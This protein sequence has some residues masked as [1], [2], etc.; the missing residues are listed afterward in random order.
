[1]PKFIFPFVLLLLQTIAFAEDFSYE[2]NYV[3]EEHSYFTNL[4]FYEEYERDDFIQNCYF[5][6]RGLPL[7]QRDTLGAFAP[8][9]NMEGI[10]YIYERINTFR[11]KF[12][13]YKKGDYI[14]DYEDDGRLLKS[15]FDTFSKTNSRIHVIFINGIKTSYDYFQGHLKY[16]QSIIPQAN[17]YGVYNS[18]RSFEIDILECHLGFYGIKTPPVKI[19]KENIYRIFKEMK[20]GDKV[21]LVCHSQGALHSYN[22]LLELPTEITHVIK[23]IAVAPAK[24][25]PID[26]ARNSINI[27]SNDLVPKVQY[28][29]GFSKKN[30]NLIDLTSIKDK[31]EGIHSF[32]SPTYREFLETQLRGLL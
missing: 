21:A 18:T 3:E 4:D 1:M 14:A 5:Y 29:Y 23:V 9:L 12:N 6:S 17:I 31:M 2:E 16:I 28:L 8:D 15:R 10:G 24:F 20:W 19:L 25:I 32:Q 30:V 26:L 22:A 7:I 11:A 27:I 13:S